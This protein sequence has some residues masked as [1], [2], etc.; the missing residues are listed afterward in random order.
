VVLPIAGRLRDPACEVI[1]E[2]AP[3]PAPAA[4]GAMTE[5][6]AHRQVT[7]DLPVWSVLPATD[8]EDA[9]PVVAATELRGHPAVD[10]ARAAQHLVRT[11]MYQPER[12]AV[13]R[14]QA[15][16]AALA[17]GVAPQRLALELEVDITEV[18]QMAQAHLGR[19]GPG[20]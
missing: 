6:T 10:R 4:G 12:F 14:D 18:Q 13:M 3:E 16:H 2:A 20:S 19:I 5:P 9:S 1:V 8:A 11:V 17:D 15:V 7:P